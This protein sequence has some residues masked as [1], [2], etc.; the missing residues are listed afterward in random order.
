MDQPR[1][2][3]PEEH[4]HPPEQYQGYEPL[5]NTQQQ[6]GYPPQKQYEG[7][8]QNQGYPPQNPGYPPQGQETNIQQPDGFSSQSTSNTTVVAQVKVWCYM[9]PD[10]WELQE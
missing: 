5:P 10:N 6:A 2:Y 4:H 9:S 7:G 1:S 3:S 8:Y